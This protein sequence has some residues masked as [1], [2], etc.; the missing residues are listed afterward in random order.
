ML[1][2]YFYISDGRIEELRKAQAVI[3]DMIKPQDRK[4]V[5]ETKKK[6]EQ[7]ER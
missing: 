5:L 2:Q 3:Q 4:Q 6:Q 7:G 1:R